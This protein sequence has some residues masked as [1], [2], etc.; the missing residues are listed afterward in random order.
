MTAQPRPSA[1]VADARPAQ[2]GYAIGVV[3]AGRAGAVLGAA[4]QR[5]GHRVVA[6]SGASPGSKAR[7]AALLPD[8]EIR[9]ATAVPD[10]VDLVL[11]A[12]PDDVLGPIIAE[13][14]SAGALRSGQLVGHLSGAHGLALLAPASD[15]GAQPF[16]IHPAMTFTGTADDL[17]RL[18]G[19]SYG[20][21]TP[22]ALAGM[23][24]Q[25]VA[26]LRGKV[27]WIA[28]E[29]RA[30]YHAALVH[31]AN[32]LIT[33]VNEAVD[34]LLDAGVR[35]PASVLRPLLIASL[36][37][38]LRLGDAA[39]TGPVSRGDAGTVA[40]HLDAFRAV[41]PESVPPYAVLARRTA[42]RAIAAGRLLQADAAPLLDVLSRACGAERA[43]A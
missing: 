3:G 32:H 23:V 39:L 22:P 15:A 29:R 27:E 34:R 33:L 7:I 1:Q 8:A 19:I 18:E 38:T 13:L 41:A 10:G 17:L 21:T 40:A 28:E 2:T 5:A 9:P 20:V 12:V 14:T 43:T 16:A 36:D 37:N 30:L 31:G 24:E 25:L 11:F 26:D 6:V 35:A 4:L 42:D